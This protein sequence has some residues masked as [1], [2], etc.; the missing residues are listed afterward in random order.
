MKNDT[1]QII[2]DLEG[3]AK[4]LATAVDS[5]FMALEHGANVWKN[6]LK[7]SGL[8]VVK[9]TSEDKHDEGR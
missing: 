7:M 2:R 8:D 1:S 4:A 6:F 5:R 9:K 3:L